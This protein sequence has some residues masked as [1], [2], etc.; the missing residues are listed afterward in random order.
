MKPFE[1]AIAILDKI[2][3]WN[4]SDYAPTLKAAFVDLQNRLEALEAKSRA[5]DAA[6]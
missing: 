2:T 4:V 1:Q 3:M 5:A 6:K